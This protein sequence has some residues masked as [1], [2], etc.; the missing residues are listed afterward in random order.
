VNKLKSVS[1]YS[2]VSEQPADSSGRRVGYYVEV[3]WRYSDEQVSYRA[4]DYVCAVAGPV[5][6]TDDRERCAI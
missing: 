6:T 5:K 3:L 1:D 2:A 4:A